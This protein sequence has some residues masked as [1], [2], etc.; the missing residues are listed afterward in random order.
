MENQLGAMTMQELSLKHE[1]SS[2]GQRI[3]LN[4]LNDWEEKF[5]EYLED[6]R[7]GVDELKEVAPQTPEEQHDTF[8]L[9]KRVIDTLIERIEI[10]RIVTFLYRSD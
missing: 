3:N 4:P 9:K 8:V 2:L 6:L 1:L 5:M 10:D 7:I